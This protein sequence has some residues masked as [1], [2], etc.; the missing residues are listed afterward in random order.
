MTCV[1]GLVQDNTIYIGGDSLASDEKGT[2]IVG[3]A[4]EKVFINDHVIMGFCG[5]FRV[6]QLLRHA[7]T[8]PNQPTKQEDDM[9]YM[10]IDFV[11]ALRTLQKEKGSMKKEDEEE[12]HPAE[13]MV[14][15]RKQLYIVGGDFDVGRPLDNY[16]AIGAGAQIA[17]G[18][19]HATKGL[20]LD[21]RRRIEMALE[22]AE[23]YDAAVRR[24]F[25][26]LELKHE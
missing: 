15:Y 8:V 19:M 1:V 20:V 18:S 6:G 4:D 14:G 21:P 10:V 23:M 5:S 11:D 24:P 13:L 3:R 22:A 25:T 26:I 17:F 9:A 7:L 16:Y 2:A 12:T